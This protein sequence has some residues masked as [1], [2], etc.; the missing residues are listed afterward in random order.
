[1]CRWAENAYFIRTREPGQGGRSIR[2]IGREMFDLA[3]GATMSAKKDG[4][5]NMG[6]FIATRD[7]PLAARLKEELILFEGFPTYGGLA[8]RDLEA[9][10]IGLREATDLRYLEHRVGQVRFLADLLGSHAIP[11]MQPPGG[12]GVY[13]DV[14]RFLPHL[15]AAQLPGQALA[16]EVYREGA[17]RGVEIG[18]IMFEEEEPDRTR[19]L[20]FVRLCDTPTGVHRESPAVR[21]RGRSTGLGA[22]NLHPGD[23]DGR[24]PR[25]PPSLHGPL[26]P[27]TRMR[28]DASRGAACWDSLSS[29]WV[30]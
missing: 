1:M 12:H 28:P 26:R 16:V 23:A 27:R 18:A 11:I 13:L 2:D 15:T 21:R 10:S 4:L 25:T 19:S 17:V 22:A 24:G 3:D 14:R 5:V 30:L 7:A 9:M 8:R 20:E 6:G 29:P